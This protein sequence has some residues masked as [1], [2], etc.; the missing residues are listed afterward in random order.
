MRNIVVL[1][2][3]FAGYHGAR[4]IEKGLAGRRRVQL[5]VVS[6]RAEFVFT[7][8]LS[9]VASGEMAPDDVTTSID[10]AFGSRTRVI[11]DQI[12]GVDLDR[13]Q[14]HGAGGTIDFDYLLIAT[15]GSRDRGAFSGADAVLGPHSLDDAVAIDD[16]IEALVASEQRPLRFSIIGGSTTGVEWAAELATG[17]AADRGLAI[18]NRQVE[19]DLFE[20][21]S[22]LLPDHSER[23]ADHAATYLERL[24]VH[25]HFDHRVVEASATQLELA[26]GTR[27]ATDQ[28]FHCAGRV[29]ASL[30]RDTALEIDERG[31]IYVNKRLQVD[32]MTGVYVAGDAAA[33]FD[34]LPASSNPQ[35]A[36]QQG[37]WAARNLLAAMS[38]RT[39][40][41]LEF[42]DRGNF[43]TLGRNEAAL[44]LGGILLEGRAAWLAYR[45]YYTALMPRPIQKARLLIDWIARRIASDDSDSAPPGLP[46]SDLS[47]S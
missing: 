6:D 2:C 40:K 24:G 47:D 25:L 5:T 39:Q 11:V 23:L 9:G 34:E 45:L 7:P 31:R 29:G 27:R 10:S 30:W 26:D 3:G 35:L 41:P 36:L 18:R 17:L 21:G 32:D 46:D 4:R 8:L 15:G 28:N 14:L 20:A 33:P 43:V 37:Q 12:E 44:E 22:R 19:I 13:R 1:G 16:R 42:E 38:G